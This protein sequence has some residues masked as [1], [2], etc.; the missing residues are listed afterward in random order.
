MITAFIVSLVASFV[1]PAYLSCKLKKEWFVCVLSCVMIFFTAVV[2]SLCRAAS[3][4][5]LP[6]GFEYVSSYSQTTSRGG[7]YIERINNF[8]RCDGAYYAFDGCGAAWWI[9][10]AQYNWVELKTLESFCENCDVFCFLPNCV[11]CG[12]EIPGNTCEH[13]EYKHTPYCGACGAPTTEGG[14]NG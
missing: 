2:P 14:R 8:I 7:I 6:H 12:A 9:P 11:L 4:N 13:V 10:G 1:L 3:D 5:N